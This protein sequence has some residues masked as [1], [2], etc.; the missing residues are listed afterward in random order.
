[1]QLNEFC[2]YFATIVKRGL[3]CFIFAAFHFLSI[4]AAKETLNE[5]CG[6]VSLWQQ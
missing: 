5:Y 3:A 4:A 6:F 1:V 2:A